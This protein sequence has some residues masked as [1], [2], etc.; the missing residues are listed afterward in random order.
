MKNTKNIIIVALLIAVLIMAVGYSA[1]ASELSF[2]GNA[3]ITGEWDV[4]I[5]NIEIKEASVG[6]DPGTPKYTN[7]SATFDA[8][9]E[10]PGDK[11]TYEITIT[12]AGTIDAKLGNLQITPDDINGSNAIEYVIINPSNELLAGNDTKMEV[13]VKYDEETTEVPEIRT[14]TITGIIEYVQK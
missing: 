7:T 6:T 14:K 5:T 1:F 13:T 11:I 4:K 8:K 10:K 12:N 2:N 9:L 3:E